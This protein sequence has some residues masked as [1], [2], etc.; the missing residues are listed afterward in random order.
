MCIFPILVLFRPLD[1]AL[2]VSF[3][4][5]FIFVF[6]FIW[7]KISANFH[8]FHMRRPTTEYC[9]DSGKGKVGRKNI[10]FPFYPK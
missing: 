3:F 10:I 7:R 2:G 4:L 6:N 1:P 9:T 5:V 8:H